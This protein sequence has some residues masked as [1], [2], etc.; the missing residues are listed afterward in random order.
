[1]RVMTVMMAAVL[2]TVVVTGRKIFT[3][4]KTVR[5]LDRQQIRTMQVKLP[6]HHVMLVPVNDERR[7][8]EEH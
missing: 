6:V 4:Q 3:S 1:M 8:T 5:H 2:I 7:H